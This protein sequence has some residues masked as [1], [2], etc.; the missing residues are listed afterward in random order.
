MAN[1]LNL[2]DRTSQGISRYNKSEL[3]MALDLRVGF[4]LFVASIPTDMFSLFTNY[5][6]PQLLGVVFFIIIAVRGKWFIRMPVRAFWYFFAY[7]GMILLSVQWM[8]PYFFAY[9]R[10]RVFQLT[11]LM[12]FFWVCAI[13]LEHKRIREGALA[14]FSYSVLIMTVLAR[15]RVPG[16][17]SE[18]AMEIYKDRAT[19][20]LADPNQFTVLIG[21][22]FLI[23]YRKATK[24][25]EDNG[26]WRIRYFPVLLFLII[27]I[28]LAGSRGGQIA[29]LGGILVAIF[30]RSYKRGTKRIRNIGIIFIVAFVLTSYFSHDM[31][32]RWQETIVGGSYSGREEIFPESINMIKRK[33]VLGFGVGEHLYI[34]GA[35]TGKMTRDPHSSFM[36]VVHEVGLVGGAPYIIGFLLCGVAAVKKIKITGDNMPLAYWTVLFIASND[37]TELYQKMTWFLLALAVSKPK[38]N[39]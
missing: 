39:H 4:Y 20:N 38:E 8:N 2:E 12:L 17:V 22:T 27:E 25:Y 3:P 33:P 24:Y 7:Y 10:E 5:S 35:A 13:L 31:S 34:L 19:V 18:R 28:V 16:F 6:V 29:V 15:L 21:I 37:I 30:A 11:Q 23:F 14:A 32:A 26:K 36:W 1:T 9:W